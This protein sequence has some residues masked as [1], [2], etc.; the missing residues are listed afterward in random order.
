MYLITQTCTTERVQT[1]PTR[2]KIARRN[3]IA[4]GT[5]GH[6][7]TSLKIEDFMHSNLQIDIS[8]PWIDA[9]FT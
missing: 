6:A 5:R 3:K 7:Q 4:Q 2:K 8:L 9:A 1:R